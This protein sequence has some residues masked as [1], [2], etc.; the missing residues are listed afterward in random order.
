MKIN[1]QKFA[2][3]ST[4][5]CN[6]KSKTQIRIG[7]HN[8]IQISKIFDQTAFD[9]PAS[10]SHFLEAFIDNKVSGI[11]VIQASKINEI[12]STDIQSCFPIHSAATTDT[13]TQ[14]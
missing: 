7:T 1:T 5:G 9:K 3:K 14:T 6:H 13:S 10:I 11:D 2:Q 12:I 8:Q 4:C